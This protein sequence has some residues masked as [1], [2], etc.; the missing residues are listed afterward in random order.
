MYLA[1]ASL[2]DPS[3]GDFEAVAGELR[4]EQLA[5]R[6]RRRRQLLGIAAASH[7]INVGVLAV[8]ALAGT[9]SFVTVGLFAAAAIISVGLFAVLSESGVS[10]TWQDHFFT[11]PYTGATFLILLAFTYFAPQAAVVFLSAI[12][13]V[14][15]TTALRASI[16]QALLAWTVI[17]ASIAALYLGTGIPLSLPF[18]T[19]IERVGTLM[20]FSLTVGRILFIGVF[21]SS[22]RQT[23]YQRGAELAEAYQRIEQLAEL[24]ELTGAYNRRCIM[25][26]LDDEI[27]RSRRNS[28]ACTIALIDLDWFKRINDM[29]GHP[30]GDEVLR[31]FAITIFA[32]IR[33]IDRFGR[34]G[35]E[36]FLLVLPETPGA[37]AELM[38]ERLRDI[39]ATLDWSAF[40]DRLAVT[41]SA[42]IATLNPG[43]TADALLAR[44]DSAL[45][46][47][48]H[49]GRNRVA[50]A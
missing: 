42:G 50:C 45:Y 48:K 24:D 22:L 21:A 17:T 43:D 30:T 12:L 32:N 15:T 18:D 13:L 28:A 27:A 26:M 19:P 41:I 37:T 29:Y 47:A 6:L 23:L 4:P 3:N 38:L 25:R 35:G 49:R 39:V 9:I 36:E 1:H 31:T 33:S 7:I 16:R 8:Y 20:T 34:H 5:R 44:A 40:S 2:A 14:A 10:D 11:G 46:A